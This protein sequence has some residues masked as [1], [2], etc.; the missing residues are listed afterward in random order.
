MFTD[1]IVRFAKL[2]PRGGYKLLALLSDFVPGLR[3]YPVMLPIARG[4]VTLKVNLANNV[5]FPLLKYGLYRHQI[6]EDFIITVLLKDDDCVVDVGANIGYVSLVCAQ[7][8]S[9][10][11]VYA[12][13][14]SAVTFEYLTQ[15]AA[16]VRQLRP[17]QLAI[18]N[19]SGSV[20]FIDEASSDTSHIAGNKDPRGYL[21]DCCTLD[22]WA[23]THN[24]GRIDFLKIDAEGHDVQ[25]IEG[26]GEV[27]RRHHP[28]IEFEAFT[29]NDVAQIADTLQRLDKTAGYK[30][31]RAMNQYPFS[32]RLIESSTNNY[33]AISGRR[34]CEVPD[35][36]FRR[37]FLVLNK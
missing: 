12:F 26:A 29:P 15:M 19:S 9:D 6:V 32:V 31:F 4:R 36:L 22:A 5:F 14:P 3:H 10:G 28:V 13:E 16:Q 24:I 34:L 17:Y 2:M 25:V 11:V 20:R 27:I 23:S 30:I 18:S 8:V 7:C 1:L 33:F 35:F 21:V 37:S